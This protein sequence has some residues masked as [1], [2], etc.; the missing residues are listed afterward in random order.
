V[1]STA[2]LISDNPIIGFEI[3]KDVA[4]IA[5]THARLVGNRR[6]GWPACAFIVCPVRQGEHDEQ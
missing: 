3:F 6:D 4:G 1:S 5:I 2:R